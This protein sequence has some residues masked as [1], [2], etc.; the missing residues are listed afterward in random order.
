[1][2][3]WLDRIAADTAMSPRA[4]QIARIIVD[5]FAGPYNDCARFYDVDIG[6]FIDLPNGDIRAL[7]H[8]LQGAGYLRPLQS[9]NCKPAYQLRFGRPIEANGGG[10][11]A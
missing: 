11:A 9:G 1:M 10:E 2:S 5:R 4:Y 8:Q 7:R 3:S 6:A